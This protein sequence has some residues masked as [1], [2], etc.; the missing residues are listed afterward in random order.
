MIPVPCVPQLIL[1]GLSNQMVVTFK[2]ENTVTFK[3]LFLKDYVDG[4]GDS[5]AVYT[6][7]D[8]YDHVFYTV[9]KVRTV[10]GGGARRCW[11]PWAAPEGVSFAST[12]PSPT[13]PSAATPTCEGRAGATSRPS[14]CASSTTAKGASTPPTTPSTS[15]PRSSPVR[16]GDGRDLWVLGRGLGTAGGGFCWVFWLR[17]LDLRRTKGS[18]GVFGLP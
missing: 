4:A 10:P 16:G 11:G 8:L 6:Q 12:W 18:A 13:R 5:Y 3:H 7:R 1:F 15:T 9:E 14:C 2:E 17:A